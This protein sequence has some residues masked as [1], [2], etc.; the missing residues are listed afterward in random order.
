MEKLLEKLLN[1]ACIKMG[2][3]IDPKQI[4]VIKGKTNINA[5]EFAHF[6]LTAE[7]MDSELEIELKRQLKNMFI[8]IVGGNI[9]E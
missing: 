1:D 7:G 9:L 6:I 5:N 4:E 3:C 8:E 2:F